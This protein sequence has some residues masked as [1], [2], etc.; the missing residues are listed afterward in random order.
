MRRYFK[1][2]ITLLTISF[3][4]FLIHRACHDDSGTNN[5]NEP[6]GIT[7]AIRPPSPQMD[8]LHAP[9]SPTPTFDESG[10]LA[11]VAPRAPSSKGPQS[12]S[13]AESAGPGA[14]TTGAAKEKIQGTWVLTDE[15]NTKLELTIADNTGSLKAHLSEAGKLVTV[16]QKAQLLAGENTVYVFGSDPKIDGRPSTSSTSGSRRIVLAFEFKA[17]GSAQ[18]VWLREDARKPRPLNVV[19]HTR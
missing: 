9:S 10:P 12:G 13:V 3:S 11:G 2:I 18:V 7:Q 1:V 16:E 5:P 17:D 15:G 14:S 4:A 8:R 19:S 6:G